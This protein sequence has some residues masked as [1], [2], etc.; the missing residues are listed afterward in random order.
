MTASPAEVSLDGRVLG[1][2]EMGEEGEASEATVFEYHED[3]G[4][5]WA[6]YAGG[7][8]RL[9]FLVGTHDG[10]EVDFRYCQPNKR[11]ATANGHCS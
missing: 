3:S 4:I 5:V 1:V 2:A 11:G 9:G 7:D 8:V 10:D 6:R